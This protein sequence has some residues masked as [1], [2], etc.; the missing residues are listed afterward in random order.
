MTYGF[1]I[2]RDGHVIRF[3]VNP[4]PNMK[5]NLMKIFFQQFLATSFLKAKQSCRIKNSRF[6]VSDSM[7][8]L[9]TDQLFNKRLKKA[10]NVLALME[11]GVESHF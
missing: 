6:Q 1:S 3:W 7:M 8:M 4:H 5:D 10:G 9:K 11:N 2:Q